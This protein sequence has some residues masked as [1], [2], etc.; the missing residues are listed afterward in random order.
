M[1][2]YRAFEVELLLTKTN[3]SDH[4]KAHER[5]C[6]TITLFNPVSVEC[7]PAAIEASRF[8]RT[9]HPGSGNDVEHR[10]LDGMWGQLSNDPT[11]VSYAAGLG[12]HGVGYH[13]NA[14]A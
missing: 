2:E 3:G 12:R 6:S 10:T 5:Y 11:L 7:D 14:F 13:P 9:V 4:T 8:R 1:K